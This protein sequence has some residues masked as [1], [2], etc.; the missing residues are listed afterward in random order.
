[1]FDQQEYIPD[2]PLLSQAAQLLLQ[3]QRRGVIQ[4]AEMDQ[5]SENSQVKH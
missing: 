2:P 4:A 1:M 5:G 3:S